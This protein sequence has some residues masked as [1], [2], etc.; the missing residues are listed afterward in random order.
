MTPETTFH[1]VLWDDADK[2][3]GHAQPDDAMT[4]RPD[5]QI[6][7]VVLCSGKVYYDLYETRTQEGIDDVYL[8]R[9][10]QL[11][12]FP[13]RSLIEELGRF[14]QAEIIWCQEE[15]RNQGSWHFIEPNIEWVLDHINAKHK[16]PRYAG[17]TASA[18]TATGQ[19]SRHLE[20]QRALVEEA[21]TG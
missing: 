5:D 6:R 2:R 17:R 11:Y 16:R 9:V 21:L 20:E 12:P 4:I 1:R 14:K 19:L 10:E 7:R 8:M 18:S 13:A 15:P 3:E